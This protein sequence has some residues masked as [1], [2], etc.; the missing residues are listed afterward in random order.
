VLLLRDGGNGQIT[1]LRRKNLDFESD[2]RTFDTVL[3]FRSL[4]RILCV[5]LVQIDTEM[6]KKY[7]EQQH[8]VVCGKLAL[9][10]MPQDVCQHMGLL[11][12]K[13]VCESYQRW[14]T[15]VPNFGTL[16]IQVLELFAMYAT[17]GQTDGWT[18]AKLTAPS[19]RAGA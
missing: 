8:P 11:T 9:D 10:D 15:F 7:T 18:K 6:A 13:L 1:V 14:G 4:I 17:D 3:I 16:G 12:L 5:S 19:L 2:F